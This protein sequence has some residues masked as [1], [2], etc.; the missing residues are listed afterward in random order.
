MTATMRA[1]VLHEPG[2][3]DNLKLEEVVMPSDTD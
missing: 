3:A 2:P 1:I